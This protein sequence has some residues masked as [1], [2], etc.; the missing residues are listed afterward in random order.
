MADFVWR[1]R[2]L[3]SRRRPCTACTARRARNPPNPHA[4]RTIRIPRC[5]TSRRSSD[6]RTI[7]HGRA[8]GRLRCRWRSPATPAVA[9]SSA[10]PATGFRAWWTRRVTPMCRRCALSVRSGRVRLLTGTTVTRLETAADGSTVTHAVGRRSGQSVT[11]RAARFVVAAGAVNSAALFL[12]SASDARPNGL[13]NGSD[14]V[15]RNYMVHNSTFFVAIDP[16]RA[17]ET[18]FQKTLGLNDWYFGAPD[19]PWPLGNVQM[20]GK[21]Q[22]PMVSA[23]RPWAPKA[24]LRYMTGHSVD[25][26]LTSED[27]PVRTNRVVEGPT[28]GSSCTGRPTI[29]RRTDSWSG[30]RPRPSAARAFRWCSPIAWVSRRIRTCA[31]LCAWVPIRR[32]A[33]WTPHA[34]PTSCGMSG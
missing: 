22:A 27:L 10:A 3:L 18:S 4:A 28:I 32:P 14:Q 19:W 33:C 25:L 24:L 20:L 11:I 8:C 1:P 2:A 12:R 26:Y 6:S 31:A 23:A 15:G 17:N 21:L 34:E 16:R 9:V 29:C 30:T 7:W 13:A 5:R